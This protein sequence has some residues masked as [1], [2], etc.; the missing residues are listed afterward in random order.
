LVIITLGVWQQ[1][2]IIPRRPT[3]MFYIVRLITI[4]K[5]QRRIKY[6]W[7]LATHLSCHG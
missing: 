7:K 6:A 1:E 2:N 5:N 4:S 3:R